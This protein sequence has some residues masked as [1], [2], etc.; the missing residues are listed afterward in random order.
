MPI[1]IRAKPNERK[2]EDLIGSANAVGVFQ[3]DSNLAREI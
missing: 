1:S 2:S 3:F